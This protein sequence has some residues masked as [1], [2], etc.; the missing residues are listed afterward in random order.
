MMLDTY[1]RTSMHSSVITADTLITGPT[2]EPL[3]VDEV[4]KALRFT[5]T[6]ED[7]LLDLWISAARQ[8]FEEQTGRQLMDATWE[9]QMEGYPAGVIELPHPP[10]IAV[11]SIT[12]PTDEVWSADNY[13][14]DAP[15]GP[16]AARGRIVPVSGGSWPSSTGHLG[17]VRVRYRAG[18][19][20]QPGAVPELIKA[21]LLFLV[22]HFHKFRAETY[23]ATRGSIERIP[24]GAEA[25][26]RSYRYSALPI[27]PIRRT[28][29]GTW[30]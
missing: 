22:G 7:T 8:Y 15:T 12:H 28:T 11:V 14:V 5:S 29:V 21:A 9:Y 24:I 30:V 10:L 17:S 16:H 2:I 13:T 3:D 23:E 20:T 19:G 1:G 25:I 27:H 4:K 26:I 18:Y 6:S